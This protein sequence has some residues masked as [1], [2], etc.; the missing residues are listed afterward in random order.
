MVTNTRT[1]TQQQEFRALDAFDGE[2]IFVMDRAARTY[3][4]TIDQLVAFL[5]S[6]FSTLFLSDFSQNVGASTG[7][8]YAWNGGTV[9]Q[10]NVVTEVAAGYLVLPASETSYIECSG[11]GTVS[12]NI[13]GFT[14]GRYPMAIVEC[15]STIIT[16]VNDSRGAISVQESN[17]YVLPEATT[18]SLGGVVV[19]DGLMVT[20]G[21]ISATGLTNPMTGYGDMIAGGTGGASVRVA[22]GTAGQMLTTTEVDSEPLP[23]WVSL[24]IRTNHQTGTA[25][26]P[27]TADLCTGP[28]NPDTVIFGDN[29]ALI[30]FTIENDSTLGSVEGDYLAAFQVQ[31]GGAIEFAAGSEVTILTSNNTSGGVGA[32]IG[33]MHTPAANTWIIF[34]NVT[35]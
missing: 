3:G 34:G 7:L 25:Y 28:P 24:G 26:T 32:P 10:D 33:A 19:G 35:S 8:T 6:L 11:T 2:E 9:R 20:D 29:A 23:A 5:K 22:A 30:T 18:S 1:P 31:S 27:V 17:N 21:V 16:S 15:N 4:G 14:P 13:S 12:T